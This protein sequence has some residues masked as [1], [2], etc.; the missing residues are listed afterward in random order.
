MNIESYSFGKIVI[1]GKAYTQDIIIYLERIE[2][3]WWR[4]AGH[5][6]SVDDIGNILKEKP[7]V[8]VIGK[9]SP[10]MMNVSAPAKKAL[11]SSS[12]ILI[13]EP[14]EEA[15][16]SYNEVSKTSRACG[17]FHLTC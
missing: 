10:G 17:A 2:E 14:T 15:I 13:E 9:G 11:A 12:I 1:N 16:K 5:S 6:V 8:L 3:G 7:D 4:K